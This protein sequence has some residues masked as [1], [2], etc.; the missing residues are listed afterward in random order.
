MNK[1]LFLTALLT[2]GAGALSL[3]QAYKHVANETREK[4][5]STVRTDLDNDGDRDLMVGAE[6]N[7]GSP[8]MYYCFQ[9]TEED[10]TLAGMVA[11]DKC[12]FEVLKTQH[13]G[14]SDILYYSGKDRERGVLIRY[15][16]SGKEWEVRSAYKGSARLMELTRPLLDEQ[17]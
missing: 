8:C 3:Q 2:A 16:H 4:T 10:Y 5:F 15:E 13:N 1:I 9:N 6:C 11:L 14:F 7:P 17:K 12:C